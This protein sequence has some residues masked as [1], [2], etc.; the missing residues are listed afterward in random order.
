MLDFSPP[1]P[2]GAVRDEGRKPGQMDVD[3]G[4]RDD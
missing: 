4:M 2:L 3:N 1:L